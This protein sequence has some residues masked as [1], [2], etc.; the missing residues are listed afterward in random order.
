MN[1]QQAINVLGRGHCSFTSGTGPDVDE[2][3]RVLEALGHK[4]STSSRPGKMGD[5]PSSMVY[6][7]GAQVA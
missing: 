4:V 7:D 1:K 3:R 5:T 6:I 2:A